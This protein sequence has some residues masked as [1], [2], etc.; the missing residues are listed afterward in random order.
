MRS[1][2]SLVLILLI[3]SLLLASCAP[4]TQEPVKEEPAQEEPAK[5]EPKKEE[6][7]KEEPAAEEYPPAPEYID[8]GSSIA[9]TGNFGSLGNLVLP[10]Y[11]IA[12]EHINADGGVFVEEYNAYIPLRLTYYDDESDPA[13]AAS[14]MEDVYKRQDHHLV[15]CS[16]FY[17]SWSS[18]SCCAPR[19]FG[20]YP[21]CGNCLAIFPQKNLYRKGYPRH[22]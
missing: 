6:P 10:G 21:D 11:E 8:F 9:L 16:G 4:A 13:N 22:G 7:A 17:F 1:R 3:A 5:E 2:I 18:L 14:K 12:I 20:D 19:Q 15:F